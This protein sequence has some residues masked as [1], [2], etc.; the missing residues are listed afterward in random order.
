MKKTKV[1]DNLVYIRVL[2]ENQYIL[3]RISGILSALSGQLFESSD[4]TRRQEICPEGNAKYTIFSARASD[5]QLKTIQ[6]T[7]ARLY[8]SE[9]ISIV[10]R[11]VVE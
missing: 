4:D 8:K 11:K 6:S 7:F 1:H 3:G 5:S 2:T 9:I 10:C